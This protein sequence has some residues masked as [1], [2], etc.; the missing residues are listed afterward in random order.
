MKAEHTHAP[1]C[2]RV[3]DMSTRQLLKLM[4]KFDT[5]NTFILEMRFLFQWVSAGLIALPDGKPRKFWKVSKS[6]LCWLRRRLM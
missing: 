1:K 3:V 4:H 5:G 6:E 2:I